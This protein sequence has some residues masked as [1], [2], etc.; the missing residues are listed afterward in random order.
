MN[1]NPLVVNPE[2]SQPMLNGRENTVKKAEESHAYMMP[3]QAT[4]AK[5]V[6]HPAALDGCRWHRLAEPLRVM[7]DPNIVE[8]YQHDYQMI[9]R[10]VNGEC[11]QLGNPPEADVVVFQRPLRRVT[12]ELIR[13]LQDKLGKKVVVEIDDDFHALPKGH[14]TR[15][16][17]NDIENGH[18]LGKQWLMRSCQRADLVTV[19]TP[20]LVERYGSHGRCVILPNYI[21]EK[22]LTLQRFPHK[23]PW[24]GWL[25]RA[26]IHVG[27]LDVVGDGLVRALRDTRAEFRLIGLLEGVQEALQLDK[28]VKATGLVPLERYT[29]ELA[30]LDIGICPLAPN[31]LNEAKS[32][33]KPLEMAACGV[34]PVM[35]PSTEYL[36]LHREYGIGL[37]AHTPNEWRESIVELVQDEKFRQ[38]LALTARESISQHLT[39]ENNAWRWRKAWNQVF[40]DGEDIIRQ[41]II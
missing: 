41:R 36:R 23:R 32:W 10:V 29:Q 20:A 13:F 28:P 21:A 40:V 2:I 35:S 11:V 16:A 1:L 8:Q 12:F 17:V 24:V 30:Q 5:V 34:V 14:A 4:E 6:V 7:N 19:T 18:D 27:D 39:I 15:S 26:D 22:C 31:A 33:L 25:G 38:Q 9:T 3:R 37:I